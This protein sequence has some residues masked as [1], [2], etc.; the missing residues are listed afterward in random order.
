[1]KTDDAKL[2]LAAILFALL[3][4]LVVIA[5]IALT[6]KHG[7]PEKSGMT[8]TEKEIAL[9][10]SADSVMRVLTTGDSLDLTV[11]RDTSSVLSAEDISSEIFTRLS[12]LMINTVQSPAQD[13]VG[14]AAPQIGISRRLAVVQRFDKEGE[15]FEIYPNLQI[16][17]MSG[18][19]AAGR[20]GCLSIPGMSGTVMRSPEI[21]VS[22]TDP[23][24]LETVRDTV[25]G[26][27][28][29]IFQHEA[30]HLDGILYTDK[31]IENSN[32]Q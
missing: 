30:D 23:V 25:E 12:E 21:M 2:D 14:L 7:T 15:P 19:P 3:T 16:I 27:T 5:V 20:E 22:Y 32:N 6:M 24:S 1:M 4:A 26:F 11:L 10:A 13:G 8:F 17:Q 31:M 18:E 29:V 28:S 9:V